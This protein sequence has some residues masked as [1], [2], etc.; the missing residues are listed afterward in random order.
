[1]RASP[2]SQWSHTSRW[3]VGWRVPSL[4]GWAP[5]AL[6]ILDHLVV[7][8]PHKQSGQWEGC[9]RRL[10][11]L[12]TGSW[13]ACSSTTG[14]PRQ[15]GLRLTDG[16]SWHLDFLKT[17]VVKIGGWVRLWGSLRDFTA[18]HVFPCIS[19]C[20]QHAVLDR[21]EHTH[22]FSLCRSPSVRVDICSGLRARKRPEHSSENAA[23][24]KL[25]ILLSNNID[26][27]LK[28]PIKQVPTV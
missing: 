6:R 13:V 14:R 10:H 15:H 25:F 12:R 20:C 27:D 18:F 4:D 24:C 8:S 22:V 21:C 9:C 26:H 23:P 11:L 2:G 1:M 3:A 7:V 17:W 19:V 16:H 5:D 28:F